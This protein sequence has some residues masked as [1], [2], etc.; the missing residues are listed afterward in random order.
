[1][2]KNVT[3]TVTMMSDS[4]EYNGRI[5]SAVIFSGMGDAEVDWEANRYMGEHQIYSQLDT[6][7]LRE[8]GGEYNVILALTNDRGR[9]I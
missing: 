3:Q 2:K 5:Y 9:K 6:T 4:V 7:D 1:M 8:E